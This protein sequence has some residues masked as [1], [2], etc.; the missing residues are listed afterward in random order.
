[1]EKP[2][3]RLAYLVMLYHSVEKGLSLPDFRPGFGKDKIRLLFPNCRGTSSPIRSTLLWYQLWLRLIS[4]LK[5]WNQMIQIARDS[6]APSKGF[7]KD[8]ESAGVKFPWWHVAVLRSKRRWLWMG[9]LHNICPAAPQC[10]SV[11]S[12]QISTDLVV[13]AVEVAQSAPSVCNRQ[14]GRVHAFFDG[15]IQQVMPVSGEPWLWAPGSTRFDCG[16]G[17]FRPSSPVGE[18]DPCWIDGG[19]L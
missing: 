2:E 7:R 10:P 17:F 4:T 8:C 11:S 14:S 12:P 6:P 13:S 18:R 15:S 3:C 19:T 5:R 9:R 1:M 16:L